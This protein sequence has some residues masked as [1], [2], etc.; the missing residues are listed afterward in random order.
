[1]EFIKKMARFFAEYFIFVVGFLFIFVIGGLYAFLRPQGWVS[2]IF[3]VIAIGWIV[4]LTKNFWEIIDKN[5][6]QTPDSK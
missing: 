6:K 3:L 4:Y 1:M 5:N 2:A